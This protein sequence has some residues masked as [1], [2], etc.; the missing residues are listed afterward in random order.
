MLGVIWSGMYLVLKQFLLNKN[1]VF[2]VSFL[3]SNMI[4]S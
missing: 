3:K 1:A 4:E 2:D